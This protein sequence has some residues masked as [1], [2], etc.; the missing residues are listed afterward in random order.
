MTFSFLQKVHLLP[1]FPFAASKAPPYLL[2]PNAIAT[3]FM[4][5]PRVWEARFYPSRCQSRAPIVY[6]LHTGFAL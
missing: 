5:A 4:V 6:E 3:G 2:E 1:P